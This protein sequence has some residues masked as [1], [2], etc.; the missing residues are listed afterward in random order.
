MITWTNLLFFSN[1]KIFFANI[2]VLIKDKLVNTSKRTMKWILRKLV[3]VKTEEIADKR[4]CSRQA[5]M[6]IVNKVFAALLA[7]Q[8]ISNS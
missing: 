3:V 4:F 6:H 1:P 5:D 2:S 8:L 7:K